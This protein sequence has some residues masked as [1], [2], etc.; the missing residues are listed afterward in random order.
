MALAVASRDVK[1]RASL[2]QEFA[3][4]EFKLSFF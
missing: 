2:L 4:D 3:Y 1:M